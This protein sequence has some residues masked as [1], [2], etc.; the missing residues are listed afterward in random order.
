MYDDTGGGSPLP[1]TPT[2]PSAFIGAARWVNPLNGQTLASV[3]AKGP[4]RTHRDQQQTNSEI[5]TKYLITLFL[6]SPPH[7]TH[8]HTHT[9]THTEIYDLKS[10]TKAKIY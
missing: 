9:H 8:T 10:K 1:P 4:T 7:T 6:N 5:M 3:M 2:P